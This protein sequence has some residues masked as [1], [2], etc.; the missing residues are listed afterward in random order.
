MYRKKHIHMP[1]CCLFLL[2]FVDAIIKDTMEQLIYF[3]NI[4][5]LAFFFV[6]S[7]FL[8]LQWNGNRSRLI[9]ACTML[10][11]GM[12]YVVRLTATICRQEPIAR[13]AFFSP[14]FLVMGTFLVLTLIPYVLEVVRPG[15]I[16]GR[17]MLFLMLPWA[18]ISTFYYMVLFLQGEVVIE[19]AGFDEL[20]AHLQQ[21]NVWFRF[22]LFLLIFGYLFFLHRITIRYRYYYDRWCRDNYASNDRMDISWLRYLAG[23]LVAVTLAFCMMLFKQG[24]PYYV[25]HQIAIDFVFLFAFYKGLFHEN[26]YAETFFR[27]SLDEREAL[28]S[29]EQSPPLPAHEEKSFSEHLPAYMSVVADWMDNRKPY[30]R[31]DFK[32]LDMTEVLPLNRTYLSRVFNEGFG[33]SFCQYVQDYRIEQAKCLLSTQPKMTAREVAYTCGFTS[34][35]TF[36]AA[37]LKRTGQSPKQFRAQGNPV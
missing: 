3:Q 31:K 1:E 4:L 16:N 13:E 6:G 35:S 30:L 15:W 17:R 2:L 34:E 20:A 36:Y 29:F 9:L 21:F 23:G 18:G 19:L 37:F 12:D 11:W 22:V 5:S 26:P 8:F 32:L 28:Q 27:H 33:V 7:L 25:I 24:H 10:V 14:V